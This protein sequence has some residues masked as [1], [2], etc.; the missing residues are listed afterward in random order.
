MY[1]YIHRLCIPSANI[2]CACAFVC[3]DAF[4][5]WEEESKQIYREKR[6]VQTWEDF[7][8][9]R[10]GRHHVSARLDLTLSIPP[11]PTCP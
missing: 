9:L 10:L 3:E 1:M 5:G 6:R 11:V 8:Q 4:V 2:L 7:G